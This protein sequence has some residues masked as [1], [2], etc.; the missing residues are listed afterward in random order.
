MS[1]PQQQAGQLQGMADRTMDALQSE[2]ASRVLQASK[3][4]SRQHDMKMQEQR[5]NAMLSAKQLDAQ[6]ER[7]KMSLLGGLL[8]VHRFEIDGRGQVSRY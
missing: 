8:G 3:E 5:L 2:N 1:V 7:Q 6:K 4:K